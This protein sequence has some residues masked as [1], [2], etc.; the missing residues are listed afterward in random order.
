MAE[1]VNKTFRKRNYQSVPPKGRNGFII[2][3]LYSH[4][5]LI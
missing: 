5:E 1:V 2:D 4:D 3:D